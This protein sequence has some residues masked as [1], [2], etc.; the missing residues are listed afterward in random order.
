VTPQYFKVLGIRLAAGRFFDEDDVA[1]RPL[2]AVINESARQRFFP[3]VDPIGKRVYPAPPESTVANLLPSPGFRFPRL[4]IVGV[5]GNVKQSGL[6]QPSEPELF[7]PH[8]QGAV[9]DNE[10]PSTKMFLM[11]KTDIDSLR[12]VNAARTAV[13]SIDPDQPV[14]DVATLQQRLDSSL[15][16]QRFQL[17]LFGGFAAIGLTLAAVG[18]YGVMS[19]SVRLR[20]REIGIRMALGA[21]APEVAKMVAWHGLGLGFAGVLAGVILA[22]GTTR[23]MSS[24]LF[25]VH[26]YDGLTFLG[27][28]LLLIVV[29]GAASLVPSL[30]AARTDPL[31]VL[32]IE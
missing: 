4:T 24:L 11:I 15:A 2:V 6:R 19:Y 17:F 9:K 16:S 12:F 20:M 10:T 26:T 7:V 22:G 1:G 31:A 23:L 27:S 8:A 13:Q 28:S 30:R 3:D 21:A 29:V 5:V 14:A 32:R 18:A 25:G